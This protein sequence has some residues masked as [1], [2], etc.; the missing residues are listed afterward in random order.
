MRLLL[1]AFPSSFRRRYGEELLE[2]VDAR[3]T[4]V[5]DGANL[6]LA[7]LRVRLDE[8]LRSARRIGGHGRV[9]SVGA[10][11]ALAA[12]SAALGGCVVLGSAAV[13]AGGVLMLSRLRGPVPVGG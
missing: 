10:V 12:G 11:A 3:R 2:L 4:P 8:L 7:G 9:L 6:V 13:A 5:R 1:H